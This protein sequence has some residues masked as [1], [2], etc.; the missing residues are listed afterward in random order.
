MAAGRTGRAQ[1]GAAA[2][3]SARKAPLGASSSDPP[4]ERRPHEGRATFAPNIA[5]ALLDGKIVLELR[6]PAGG[7]GCLPPQL[8][9]SCGTP[10]IAR[11]HGTRV[12]AHANASGRS[13]S[14]GAPRTPWA[15]AATE[16]DDW[17][18]SGATGRLESGGVHRMRCVLPSR[19]IRGPPACNVIRPY[20]SDGRSLPW[21]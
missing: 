20:L 3:T 21:K 13:G 6:C 7:H 9:F 17:R 19:S 15:L 16:D 12:P 11:K 2:K 8:M 5:G 18:G 4:C 14:C 1:D 10:T